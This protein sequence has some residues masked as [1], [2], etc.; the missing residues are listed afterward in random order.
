VLNGSGYLA[1]AFAHQDRVMAGVSME[2]VAAFSGAAIAIS[3]YPVLA[4]H[5]LA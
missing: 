3:L 5:R 1:R 2:L 4:G